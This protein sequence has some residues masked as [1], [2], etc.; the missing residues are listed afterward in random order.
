MVEIYETKGEF[1]HKILSLGSKIQKCVNKDQNIAYELINKF[2]IK[3][4]DKDN[5]AR[6]RISRLNF[7]FWKTL[8]CPEFLIYFATM[9]LRVLNF[10]WHS[11][12]NFL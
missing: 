2:Q 5:L 9:I 4:F 7:N 6:Y 8:K 10:L 1:P 11:T 12:V 3:I